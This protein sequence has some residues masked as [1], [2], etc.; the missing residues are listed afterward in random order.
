[1][2]TRLDTTSVNI[3]VRAGLTSCEAF[4]KW[5]NYDCQLGV[6]P[7]SQLVSHRRH[8]ALEIIVGCAPL[9]KVSIINSSAA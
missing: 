4:G 9:H 1:M 6:Q 7:P 3:N 2:A 5:K 8:K